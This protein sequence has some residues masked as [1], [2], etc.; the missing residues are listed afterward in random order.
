M[1]TVFTTLE[2]TI[3]LLEATGRESRAFSIPELKA[4]RDRLI[5]AVAIVLEESLT[6]SYAD[7]SSKR[8]AKD[9][10][11]HA[12]LV[13]N[14]LRKNDVIISFNYDC[15]ID[16]ALKRH[17]KGKWHARYGYG[18]KLGPRGSRLSGDQYWQ[19]EGGS[20]SKLETVHLEFPRFR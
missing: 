4:K 10:K 16:Y 13:L 14:T 19:P 3:R 17:G 18:L 1:E 8:E 11:H 2:H 5:Q 20:A 7:G 6:P 9:C 12:A 15:V